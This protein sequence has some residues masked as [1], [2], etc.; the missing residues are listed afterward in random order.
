MEK[1]EER[2]KIESHIL[3]RYY[4][5]G[6]HMEVLN[7]LSFLFSLWKFISSVCN[8]TLLQ[9]FARVKLNMKNFSLLT[10][11]FWNITIIKEQKN[12]WTPWITITI[13]SFHVQW[14]NC[15]APIFYVSSSKSSRFPS[16]FHCMYV[17]ATRKFIIIILHCTIMS[18]HNRLSKSFLFHYSC[19]GN[20]IC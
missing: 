18:K 9:P 17:R 16:F 1:D 11:I 8:L 4:L 13:K 20:F 5:L 2:T 19:F 14:H 15:S 12:E 7:K 3:F 6:F 10:Q